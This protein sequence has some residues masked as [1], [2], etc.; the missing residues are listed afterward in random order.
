M[1]NEE[2]H[3]FKEGAKLA[4]H[5]VTE[6]QFSLRRKGCIIMENIDEKKQ[7]IVVDYALELYSSAAQQ[8]LFENAPDEY[9][10]LLHFANNEDYELCFDVEVLTEPDE[11]LQED[12][13]F[14]L[15]KVSFIYSLKGRDDDLDDINAAFVYFSED[16]MQDKTG[17]IEWFPEGD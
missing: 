8:A 16:D 7:D 11:Y 13:S 2:F 9:E 17:A 1:W 5:H 15:Y 10:R 14:P 6:D 12:L 3:N 4:L